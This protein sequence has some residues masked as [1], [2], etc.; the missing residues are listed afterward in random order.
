M[1]IVRSDFVIYAKTTFISFLVFFLMIRRPPRST[2]T[3]HSF[4][5]RRSSDLNSITASALARDRGDSR[6]PCSRFR[7]CG[8]VRRRSEEHTSELQSLMRISYAVFCLKKKIQNKVRKAISVLYL[9]DHTP[10]TSNTRY[11]H[12]RHINHYINCEIKY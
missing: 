11:I 2:R 9:R 10:K 12:I 1:L 8:G 3:T 6:I 5:T 4:P 7:S